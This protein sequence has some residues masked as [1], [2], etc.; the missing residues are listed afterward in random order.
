MTPSHDVVVIGAGPAGSLAA[1]AC[2][3]RG[4]R[5]ALLEANPHETPRLL[6]AGDGGLLSY[7]AGVELRGVELPREGFGHVVIGGPGPALLY[8]IGDDRV[9]ACLDVPLAFGGAA[10]TLQF[11]WDGFA[12]AFP[13]HLRA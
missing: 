8:R 2:A 4:A 3:R 13:P 5:V 9:R 6:G 10:R 7:M 11:L 1:L 12:P